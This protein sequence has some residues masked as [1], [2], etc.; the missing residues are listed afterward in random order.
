MAKLP[1]DEVS[2]K[3]LA[4]LTDR[5]LLAVGNKQRY[6][7]QYRIVDGKPKPLPIEDEANVDQR[8]ARVGLM[9]LTEHFKL[10]QKG[11]HDDKSKK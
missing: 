10:V 7:T 4:Y 1:K 3:D 11:L 2:S 6:G 9:S 8:R 5:V